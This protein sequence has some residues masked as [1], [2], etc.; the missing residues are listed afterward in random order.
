MLKTR[1]GP[2]CASA[3][4]LQLTELV[5]LWH[6][7]TQRGAADPELCARAGVSAQETCLH[8][9]ETSGDHSCLQRRTFCGR[10]KKSLTFLQNWLG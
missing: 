10:G 8:G 2:P 6:A 5:V 9:L 7:I 1:E 4:H 3:S